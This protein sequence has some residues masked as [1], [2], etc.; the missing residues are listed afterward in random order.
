[1]KRLLVGLR[2]D[3]HKRLKHYCVDRDTQMSVVIRKLVEDFLAKEKA[4]KK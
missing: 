3:T 2:E 1:M 4:K